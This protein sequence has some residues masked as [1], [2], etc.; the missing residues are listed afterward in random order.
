MAETTGTAGTGSEAARRIV[1]EIV[2]GDPTM[3]GAGIAVEEAVPGR[4][5][6]SMRVTPQMANFHGMTHG[7]IIFMLA[8]SA[9]GCAA[10]SHGVHNVA[11]HCHISFMAPGS[12]GEQL[13]ATAEERFQQGRNGIYDVTVRRD[14]GSVVAELRGWSR[15]LPPGRGRHGGTNE[16]TA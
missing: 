12:P 14:D 4:V 6:L 11:Q 2:S 7:A 16:E 1:E 5:V 3:R 10:A 8:D 9:F 13:F 15:E